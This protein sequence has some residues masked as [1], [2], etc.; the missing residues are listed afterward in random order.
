[1]PVSGTERPLLRR[2]I[3]HD[4]QQEPVFSCSVNAHSHLPVYTNIH[5]IRRDVISIVEDYMTL[6]QLRDLRINISVI[7]PLVDKLYE[8]DDIS[9]VYCLLVNRAH[10]LHEQSHLNNRQNVNFTRATLCELVATRILRRFNEDNEGPEGLL[11][12]AHILVA[13]FE[14][15]QNAPEDIRQEASSTSSWS[16]HQ[17]LPAL[18]VAILSES[19]LFLSS[20]SCQKVI[21]AIYEGQVIYT[22]SSFM[23]IIPDRYKQKPISLYDP[24][25]ASLLNQ[26]RLIVP[27][28]RNLLEIFQFCVLLF[29][30][31]VFMAERD[32]SKFSI[33]EIAFSIYAFGWVLD[34][35]ATMLEHGWHVYTQN[36]WSF[37]DVTFSVIFWIYLILRIHGWRSGHE[38][39][40]QQALDVLA[41]GAPV[42][43]PRL[44]FNLLSNNLLFVC[45]R[46]M[47]VDFTL[48]T[49]LAAWCFGGFLLSLVWLG[50]AGH[51]TITVSKWMLWIW[52]GLDG[53]GIQKA[54]DFHWILGPCLMVTFAFLGNTLFLTILVSMLSNT[55]S[56]I[57]SNATAEIQYR[58]AVQTLE[59]VKS[60]AIFAYQ[61]PFNILALFVLV[62]LRWFISPRWFHK[63]HVFFVRLLNL[64]LLL[65]IAAAE[66]RLLW[67]ISFP[68]SAGAAT[69]GNETRSQWFWEKWRITTHGDIHAVFDLPPPDEMED[70]ISMDDELTHHMIRRHFQRSSTADSANLENILRRRKKQ[71]QPP[72]PKAQSDGNSDA[73]SDQ[74]QPPKSPGVGRTIS[75]RD[76]MAPFPGLRQEL[77]GILDDSP[78]MSSMTA[79]LD[80]L[81][82]S[83]ARIESMLA[84]LVN[85]LDDSTSADE[86]AAAGR[87]GTLRDLD[88]TGDDQ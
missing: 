84:R 31:L 20:T 18:E 24:R 4:L 1:M 55:F 2:H 53:T 88:H 67:P 60:D 7:R 45:L 38:N 85:D 34:Q 9:I 76:S 41:M 81:E 30:Y 58:H 16:Y 61:P 25:A 74:A 69:S 44:A 83:N 59:G 77:Q 80:A 87:T 8:L 3:S 11:I 66:R 15:F 35:F 62:P 21:D 13:G 56:T 6:E 29:L 82:E 26:Y 42:L 33:L 40:G 23:D 52:F 14:P 47:V 86:E 43:I 22:P 5:R 36:L 27:R 19:K 37:L 70:A 54:P 65:I 48:L 63:I 78:E 51:S 49:A 12:L 50:D 73:R 46:A 75:R 71:Q 64:P 10:F 17:T 39:A 28:T 72:T 57:V 68:S 32:S 79:R